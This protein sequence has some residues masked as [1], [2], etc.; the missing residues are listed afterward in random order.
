MDVNSIID[1]A[2]GIAVSIPIIVTTTKSSTS[3]NP[4]FINVAHWDDN[5][6]TC[7]V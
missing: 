6:N 1:I 3:V 2:F 4:F 7:F 5:H